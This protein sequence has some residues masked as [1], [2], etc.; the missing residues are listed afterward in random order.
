M[1]F[2]YSRIT[3]LRN[4][5]SGTAGK[6]VWIDQLMSIGIEE[7]AEEAEEDEDAED[8]EAKRGMLVTRLL[9]E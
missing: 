6:V 8:E 2:D 1:L 9:M 5:A 3:P 4:G 7:K